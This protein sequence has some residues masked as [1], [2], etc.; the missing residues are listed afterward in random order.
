MTQRA[1][2][3]SSGTRLGCFFGDCHLDVVF[4]HIQ[5]EGDTC[6]IKK[7]KNVNTMKDLKLNFMTKFCRVN[8]TNTAVSQFTLKTQSHKQL[9]IMIGSKKR[10]NRKKTSLYFQLN[11]SGSRWYFFFFFLPP[12]HYQTAHRWK[13]N[14]FHVLHKLFLRRHHLR[15]S[16]K[17]SAYFWKQGSLRL[18]ACICIPH[19][20]PTHGTL[21][22]R[23]KG[24]LNG[25]IS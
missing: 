14:L 23:K 3:G 15:N 8:F 19:V 17:S 16:K 9:T 11:Y 6:V 13:S 10:K 25:S 5:Q 18:S 2:W 21:K 4:G 12:P 20:F 1:S 22:K 24:S 7:K